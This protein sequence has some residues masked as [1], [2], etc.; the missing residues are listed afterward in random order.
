[1]R[2]SRCNV[3]RRRPVASR[4]EGAASPR[5]VAQ[6]VAI[7]QAKLA[8]VP[9]MTYSL[10]RRSA[11]VAGELVEAQDRLR[12]DQQADAVGLV[13]EQQHQDH[14]PLEPADELAAL[15]QAVL[16]PR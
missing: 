1:M 2:L 5:P 3:V 7:A 6:A 14:Q 4:G 8:S 12:R 13:G 9:M 16:R 10:A 11:G 15:G